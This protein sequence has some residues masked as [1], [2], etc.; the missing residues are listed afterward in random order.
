MTAQE[1][2]AGIANNTVIIL[3]IREPYEL[4][5]CSIDSL[6]IPMAEVSD[7]A[8]EIPSD[9]TVAVMCRSGRRAAAVVNM[10]STEHGLTN[11]VLLEG[12]ILAWIEDI[13]P[14]LESY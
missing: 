6:K 10:L 1:V 5:I 12:G 3:D 8:N 14:E 2:Q 9:K 7:R 13:A 11:I 4:D